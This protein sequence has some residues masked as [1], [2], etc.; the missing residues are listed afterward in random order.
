MGLNPSPSGEF[1]RVFLRGYHEE[2]QVEGNFTTEHTEST[3]IFQGVFSSV[4]SVPSVV[5][6]LFSLG[7]L[8]RKVA[9]FL[10][11]CAKDFSP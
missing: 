10:S 4:L 3:E 2:I 7:S 9:C 5:I 6:L 1:F 8:L 11:S